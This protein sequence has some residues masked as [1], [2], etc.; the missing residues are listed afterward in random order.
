[1]RAA[2]LASSLEVDYDLFVNKLVGEVERF[3]GELRL[4]EPDEVG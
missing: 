3:V 2:T 1:L 4:V